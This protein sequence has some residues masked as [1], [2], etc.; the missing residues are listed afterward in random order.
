M[1]NLVHG[2]A[3]RAFDVLKAPKAHRESLGEALAALLPALLA[4]ERRAERLE[5]RAA[6]ARA[7]P[8]AVL[9]ATAAAAAPALQ[10]GAQLGAHLEDRRRGTE[11][12][13]PLRHLPVQ[14]RKGRA[15]PR[16]RWARTRALGGP[17]PRLTN[18]TNLKF[19]LG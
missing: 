2:E 9:G 18:L 15:T 8:S 16:G 1:P 12:P 11:R 19:A 14:L 17:A 6:R 13:M 5:R 4:R 10:L 3:Q 7:E